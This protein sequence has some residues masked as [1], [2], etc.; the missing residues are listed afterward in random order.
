MTESPSGSGDRNARSRALDP[1]G[2]FLVV[3]PAG[4]GKTELLTQR[5][6]RL[7]SRVADPE[8]LVAITFTRKSAAEMRRR[9]LSRLSEAA[10]EPAVQNEKQD[11]HTA[12]TL[13]LAR[14][15]LRQ[16]R[17]R[18]WKL[19]ENPNRL[20]IQT[21]DSL[22]SWLTRKLPLTSG[23]GG[24]LD[25][26][27]SPDEC[28]QEAARR[29]LAELEE[30]DREVAADLQRFLLWYQ[31]DWRKS[32]EWLVNMLGR[33][34]QWLPLLGPL[35]LDEAPAQEQFKK[36]LE[37]ERSRLIDGLIEGF[38]VLLKRAGVDRSELLRLAAAAGSEVDKSSPIAL[39]QDRENWPGGDDIGFWHALKE[40]LTTKEGGWR[41]ALNKKQGVPAKSALKKDLL[42]LLDD[43][44]ECDSTPAKYLG[45]VPETGLGDQWQQILTVSRLLVRAVAHL[46]TIFAER[47]E[48]DYCEVSM[49]ADAALGSEESPGQLSL[50]LGYKIR[51][52]LV[53]EF[54]DT[55]WSQYRLLEKLVR[56]W[57]EY[58]QEDPQNPCTL[59]LVGDGMQSCYRFRGA[60]VNLFLM[61]GHQGIG[62]VALETLYL[63]RNFRSQQGIVEWLN[64]RFARI[65]PL[66]SDMQTGSVRYTPATSVRG[67]TDT[68]AVRS[69]MFCYGEDESRR[70]AQIAEAGWVARLAKE[71][72]A[73][74]ADSGGEVAI[75]VRSR[76]HLLHIIVALREA[77]LRWHA[78]EIDRLCERQFAM[79]LLSLAR[80]LLDPWDR[81]AW[82]A[83]MRAPWCGLGDKALTRIAKQQSSDSS[84]LWQRLNN[85]DVIAVLD[86]DDRLA[87]ERLCSVLK[88]ALKLRGRRTLRRWVE[89]SWLALGGPACLDKSDQNEDVQ[90]VLAL[91]DSLDENNLIAEQ[92]QKKAGQ[93]YASPDNRP[94][95][96][97]L[98]TIHKAKGLQFG[99]VIVA[100]LGGGTST[101]KS[102]LLRWEHRPDNGLLISCD[103]QDR[104]FELLKDFEKTRQ[105]QEELRLFYIACTRAI[106]R[107][108][109]TGW[110]GLKK[111]SDSEDGPKSLQPATGL[112]KNIWPVLSQDFEL[113]TAADW[114]SA[115][116][117]S[118]SKIPAGKRAGVPVTKNPPQH[119]HYWRLAAD[120]QLPAAPASFEAGVRAVPPIRDDSRVEITPLVGRRARMFGE[121]LHRALARVAEEGLALWDKQRID[122]EL[123]IWQ[124]YLRQLG[125]PRAD[126]AKEALR[127]SRALAG[128]LSDEAGRW[129]LADRT[130][131]GTEIPLLVM[132]EGTVRRRVVDRSFV[133]N[134]IRWIV[135]YKSS[136][137][138]SAETKA[139]FLQRQENLYSQQLAAYRD[140]YIKLNPTQK[141]RTALYFPLWPLLHRL[142]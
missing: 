124:S 76:N 40:L 71:A 67:N 77:G 92:L 90:A 123:P 70:S 142:S 36:L 126:C 133:E 117:G 3:A 25:I 38:H 12:L 30:D 141:V 8:E 111:D 24:G 53:D 113:F 46:K 136:Q 5:A 44:S 80:A 33:R 94:S 89:G 9:I 22:C 45:I 83:V 2:S 86:E 121:V 98:M 99:T 134:D 35:Q 6:L 69:L 135:D 32:E 19:L 16:D 114:Q 18:D 60:E 107:L 58:N 81:I 61:A 137:P 78:E 51:H 68:P 127:V 49:S 118:G 112:L 28:L 63:G 4:S 88:P 106:D 43:L 21:V 55:S 138:Y 54:Q 100:G 131:A 105:E 56:G 108:V 66:A 65:F 79:D 48:V 34:D 14:D 115:S 17:Q 96:L 37:R 102:V 104:M 64:T 116:G 59:F 129:I 139:E 85:P 75:L 74:Q 42:S 57:A 122:R 125:I 52:I 140:A 101:D 87:A 109:L 11:G 110:A 62:G 10:R 47:A 130:E 91:L 31:V 72:L 120:W 132:E 95:R 119:N 82:L 15:V 23:L 13:Q 73:A 93:L 26:T 20:K 41:K 29:L 103:A 97:K 84:S 7:L 50:R 27:D 39:L 1:L 128:A